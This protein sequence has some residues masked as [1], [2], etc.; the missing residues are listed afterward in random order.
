MAGKSVQSAEMRKN[1]QKSREWTGERTSELT[2]ADVAISC[3]IRGGGLFFK[4]FCFSY[5]MAILLILLIDF[6]FNPYLVT[7]DVIILNKTTEILLR[8]LNKIPG[9]AICYRSRRT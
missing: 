4:V 3:A 5:S 7:F 8:H 6:F 2:P 1:K 9:S